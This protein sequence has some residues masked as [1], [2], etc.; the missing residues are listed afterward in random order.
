MVGCALTVLVFRARICVCNVKCTDDGRWGPMGAGAPPFKL[1][2]AS[3]N[4]PGRLRHLAASSPFSLTL[5]L[6]ITRA[7]RSHTRSLFYFAEQ[8]CAI[9]HQAYTSFLRVLPSG[10]VSYVH[11]SHARAIFLFF[12]QSHT[13]SSHISIFARFG[14]CMPLGMQVF[15]HPGT[16]ASTSGC[17]MPAQSSSRFRIPTACSER[18]GIRLDLP[19]PV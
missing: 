5:A 7:G 8:V 4:H 15:Q 11:P 19:R 14:F 10:L 2:R 6:L 16:S 1:A 17:R 18:A 3:A 13:R 12:A 9:R